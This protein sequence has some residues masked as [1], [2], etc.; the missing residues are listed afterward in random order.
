MIN[1]EKWLYHQLHPVKLLVDW[2]AGLFSLYP[3]WRHEL[4]VG[5]AVMLMPPVVASILV[6]LF[7]DLEPY[8]R[9]RLGQSLARS[10]SR[11]T[12]AI[13][14]AGMAVMALGAWY[15]GWLLIAA[16]LLLIAAGWLLGLAQQRI[17]DGNGA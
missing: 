10:M 5:M 14:L 7:A 13:R 17:H 1:R 6:M 3:L 12:E 8:A 9:S 16:G 15:H 2:G 4:A 11:L